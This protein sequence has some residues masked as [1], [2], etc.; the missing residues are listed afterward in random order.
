MSITFLKRGEEAQKA[1]VKA[2]LET[3]QKKA[4]ASKGRR[5]WI[6]DGN[7]TQITFLDGA[8]LPDGRLDAP[9]FWQHELRNPNNKGRTHYVCVK[10]NEPTC[11]LCEGGDN[12]SLVHAFTIVDHTEWADKNGKAHPHTKTL[13]VC[14][15]ETFKRLQKIA[16]KREGLAGATFDVSRTGEKSAAVGSDF[17]FVEKVKL[18]KAQAKVWGVDDVAPYNYEEMFTY[19]TGKELRALGLGGGSAPIGHADSAHLA[20][21]VSDE[22]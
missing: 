18:D 16:Q 7:E 17:D 19:R 13:F 11:P 6:K 2:D 21:N 22:I 3:E 10:D 1:M 14:K 8:L 9:M 12:A 15:R 20:G 4:A 5:F